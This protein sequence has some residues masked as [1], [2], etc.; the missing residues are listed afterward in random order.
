MSGTRSKSGGSSEASEVPA[1]SK[2][3]DTRAVLQAVGEQFQGFAC[4]NV[5]TWIRRY[6]SI[7]HSYE[8]NAA[9]AIAVCLAPQVLDHVLV[10]NEKLLDREWS[11]IKE[12]L[13]TKYAPFED[14]QDLMR[15]FVTCRQKAGVSVREFAAEFEAAAAQAGQKDMDGHCALF[16]ANMRED[17]CAGLGALEFES[18]GQLVQGAGRVEARL[19]AHVGLK[20]EPAAV[21]A[22]AQPAAK[23]MKK[24]AAPGGPAQPSVQAVKETR[25][26]HY[27]KKIGH[28]IKDCRKRQA[29]AADNLAMTAAV[30]PLLVVDGLL[31]E[32]ALP[33]TLDTG[34]QLTLVDRSVLLKSD[35][36]LKPSSVVLHGASR[37]PLRTCGSLLVSLR[38][39]SVTLRQQVIAVDGLAQPLLLGSDTLLALGA[40][41]D[42]GRHTL[43]IG[44]VQVPIR[45]GGTATGADLLLVAFP[46]PVV[47][48]EI[49]VVLDEVPEAFEPS[50][51]GPALV[52]PLVISTGSNTPVHARPFRLS[53]KEKELV[54]AKVHEL[55]Q[56]GVIRKSASPWSSPVVPLPR[57]DDIL[58]S[59]HGS[60]IFTSL[61]LA[62]AYHQVPI[63][64]TDVEK[65][66]FVTHEGLYE[67]VVVPFGLRNAPSWFQRAIDGALGNIPSVLVYLDDILVFS[68][69]LE[70]HVATLRLVLGRLRDVRFVLNR[71]K[72][73]FGLSSVTFL[74][75]VVSADGVRPCAEKLRALKEFPA[76]TDKKDLQAFLGLIGFYRRF[77]PSFAQHARPLFDLL[78]KDAE[79]VWSKECS[80]AQTT[81]LAALMKDAV[82]QFP[83]LKS[84][85]VVTTDASRVG[86]GAVLSQWLGGELRPVQFLSRALQPAERNYTATEL[87]LLAVVFAVKR[88]RPYLFGSCFSLETDHSA[89]VWL[90]SMTGATG[91]LARWIL[92]LQEYEFTVQHKAGSENIVADALSRAPVASAHVASVTVVDVEVAQFA[93]PQIQA[94]RACLEQ[95][96]DMPPAEFRRH[97]AELSLTASGLVR[98]QAA[99]GMQ[100]VAPVALRQELIRLAHDDVTAGHQGVERT[101]GRLMAQVWWPGV[102]ADVENWIAACGKCQAGKRGTTVEAPLG[103]VVA[104]RP[105]EIVAMDVLQLPP[106]DSGVQYVLVIADYFS[107]FVVTAPL[108]DLTAGEAV[109]QFVTHWVGVFGPPSKILT[110]NGG[111]FCAKITEEFFKIL[112]TQHLRT[113][114]YHPQTD[115]M[116]E[117]FNRTLQQMLRVTAQEN[118]GAWDK[119]LGLVTF[120]YNSGLHPSVGNTPYLLML[121][122]EARLLPEAGVAQP[123]GQAAQEALEVWQE[124]LKVAQAMGHS[125]E[126]EATE[127]TKSARP[128]LQAGDLVRLLQP[129]V[130]VQGKLH[131]PFAAKFTVQAL[132][133]P[134]NATIVPVGGGRAQRVHVTRLKK[135]APTPALEI[136]E[137]SSVART[138]ALEIAKEA[139]IAPA[140][141]PARS[142]APRSVSSFGRPLMPRRPL[143]M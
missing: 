58:D 9:T 54:S 107:R 135:I 88:F 87:E 18:F 132:T 46:P 44:D 126:H 117:R 59:L 13:L 99:Q 77:V 89:L 30:T 94:V 86:V 130:G 142:A 57:I 122:R 111:N 98:R 121:A 55:L 32:R 60:S 28:L 123:L 64:E 90:R 20:T 70:D 53:P 38:I 119:C 42:I 127:R 33:F 76:P 36:V 109:S 67:Y 110:D 108:H 71:E 49:Q 105:N 8:V 62:S 83:D 92:T 73:R 31:N 96:G 39:G 65:T 27:C 34:S 51:Q 24:V 116:V 131:P 124:A 136:P 104:S 7:C 91:R 19:R 41:L 35:G 106:A 56:K 23:A 10:V 75:H 40:I 52:A 133:G 112:G 29:A 85:F 1:R 74:G 3:A 43:V 118:I 138:P 66:A 48:P 101:L 102:R 11:D 95:G 103:T 93:D 78:K 37:E 143:D 79:F 63:S 69:T 114:A 134:Y 115:G 21:V 82:L 80:A 25:S 16:M 68:K 120:A 15:R 17:I 100:L 84:P 6:E 140:V 14:K 72:C 141:N 129:R 5:K 113:T 61:D 2:A 128:Q 12:W 47:P 139:P 125:R 45:V 4:S 22:W 97:L 26:C 81:L 50:T 137:P